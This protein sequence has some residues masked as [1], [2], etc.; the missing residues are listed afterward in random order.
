MQV[1]HVKIEMHRGPVAL[2]LAPINGA[3]RGFGTGRFFQNAQLDIEAMQDSHAR[4]RLGLLGE[5]KR[6]AI[7]GDT[8]R[9]T[10]YVDADGNG[11]GHGL[12]CRLSQRSHPAERCGGRSPRT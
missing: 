7:E 8:F 4:C 12:L 5:A 1:V 2:E 11:D 9:K 10:R 3:G 6:G